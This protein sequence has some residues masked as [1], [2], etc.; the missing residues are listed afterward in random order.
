MVQY[1]SR[2]RAKWPVKPQ[3]HSKPDSLQRTSVIVDTSTS[4]RPSAQPKPTQPPQDLSRIPNSITQRQSSPNPTNIHIASPQPSD[5]GY[6]KIAAKVGG[7]QS[8]GSVQIKGST[9]QGKMEMASLWVN[10]EHRQQGISK[11]LIS[12]ATQVGKQQGYRKASLGVDPEAPGM[13][14]STLK[15]IYSRQGFKSAGKDALGRPLMEKNL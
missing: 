9:A 3:S 11:S 6:Q 13:N 14:T 15:N 12:A 5:R 10:P 8:V 4:S 2:D 1:P 7:G